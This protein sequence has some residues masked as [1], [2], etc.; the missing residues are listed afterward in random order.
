MNC[1]VE[2]MFGKANWKMV[3]VVRVV[4]WIGWSYEFKNLD[5]LFGQGELGE[6]G[7]MGQ[8]N[9]VKNWAK[10]IEQKG[11]AKT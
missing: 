5:V 8:K 9:W 4:G 6:I 2:S 11:W 3:G 1:Q 10:K 7:Q